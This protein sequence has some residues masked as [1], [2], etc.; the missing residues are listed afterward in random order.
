MAE[1]RRPSPNAELA[2]VIAKE[3]IARELILASKEKELLAKL[4]SG[5]VTQQDWH[6]WIDLA[7]APKPEKRDSNA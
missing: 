1:T 6:L 4:N 5:G 3:L 7:T 2:A